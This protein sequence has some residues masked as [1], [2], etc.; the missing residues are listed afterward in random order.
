MGS[1]TPMRQLGK[2]ANAFFEYGA[3]LKHIFWWKTTLKFPKWE[4]PKETTFQ[5]SNICC[6]L[7]CASNTKGILHPQNMPFACVCQET[8]ICLRMWNNHYKFDISLCPSWFLHHVTWHFW[9]T[10]WKCERINNLIILSSLVDFFIMWHR[11]SYNPSSPV[12][13]HTMPFEILVVFPCGIFFL[14]V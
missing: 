3:G 8:K 13:Q 10:I 6:T 1:Y 14:V 7:A 4:L 9:N 12:N 2:G 11:V 5:S